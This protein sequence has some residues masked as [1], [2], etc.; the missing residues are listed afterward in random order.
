MLICIKDDN[1]E[2]TIEVKDEPKTN[3]NVLYVITF[4]VIQT[5]IYYRVLGYDEKVTLL[6]DWV[7]EWSTDKFTDDLP[8]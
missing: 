3:K 8:S 1:K 5:Y 4:C 7:N 6:D 2:K